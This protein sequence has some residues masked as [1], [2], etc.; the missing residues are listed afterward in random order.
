MKEE[1]GE[2]EEWGIIE[3][4]HSSFTNPLVVVKKKMEQFGCAT[5]DWGLNSKMVPVR[6]RPKNP[7][8]ENISRL[9]I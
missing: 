6:E 1:V 5:M 2:D 4:S 3:K 9:L 8:K 7:Q